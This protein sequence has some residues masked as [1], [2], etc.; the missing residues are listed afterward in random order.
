MGEAGLMA[1]EPRAV[2]VT[3]TGWYVVC[4]VAMV[5][6]RYLHSERQPERFSRIT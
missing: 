5:F 1:L 3:A 6:D 4:A 2:H